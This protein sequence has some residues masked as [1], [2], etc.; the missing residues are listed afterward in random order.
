M[1]KYVERASGATRDASVAASAAADAAAATPAAPAAAATTHS[2]SNVGISMI[3][4]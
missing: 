4:D 1:S 2:E 3:A